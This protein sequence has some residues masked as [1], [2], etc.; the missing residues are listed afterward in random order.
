MVK[1]SEMRKKF[2]A[3]VMKKRPVGLKLR[4][5][6]EKFKIKKAK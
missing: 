1:I 5:F 3:R 2:V 6:G 4:G